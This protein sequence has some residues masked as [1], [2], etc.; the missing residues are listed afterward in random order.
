MIK[1]TTSIL[2]AN[3]SLLNYS[4]TCLTFA[5]WHCQYTRLTFLPVELQGLSVYMTCLF[6][7]RLID[8][9]TRK[10]GHILKLEFD[11]IRGRIVNTA[12]GTL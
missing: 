12:V 7:D 9:D 1:S 3:S 10:N 6:Y 5:E 11:L 2:S 8:Q 4:V